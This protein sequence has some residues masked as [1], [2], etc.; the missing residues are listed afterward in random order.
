MKNKIVISIVIFFIVFFVAGVIK[1]KAASV[2]GWLWGGGV[3]VDGAMPWDG[4]HTGVGLISLSNTNTAGPI[5]Y[6]VQV[7]TSDGNLSGYAWSE[8]IGWIS[9]NA[10]DVVGCP[11]APCAPQR[12]GN[13]IK[14]WARILSIKTAFEEGNSD[15]WEGWIRLNGT[16]MNGASYGFSVSGSSLT[17][18]AWSDELGAIRAMFSGPPIIT[19]NALPISINVDAVSLPQDITLSWS[20]IGASSCTKSGGSVLW[21]GALASMNGN[22]S[23]SQSSPIV[24]YQ[25]DCTGPGGSATKTVMVSAFCNERKCGGGTCN[26]ESQY[27]VSDASSCNSECSSDK[28]CFFQKIGGWKEVAP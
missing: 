19:F 12:I 7:P 3:E 9:F 28:D 17:G 10:A 27:G 4:T 21:T 23:I 11:V 5:A 13:D 22:Q 18:F 25:L 14:G 16:A 15:G 1:T 2:A 6:G 26:E 8:N 24:S 20:V